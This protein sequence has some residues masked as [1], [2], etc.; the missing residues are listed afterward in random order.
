MVS[1]WCIVA[2][3]WTSCAIFGIL[4]TF[5]LVNTEEQQELM[6]T[7]QLNKQ[8]FPNGVETDDGLNDIL[9]T[10][11][12]GIVFTTETIR[13]KKGGS[14]L[15]WVSNWYSRLVD[16]GLSNPLVIGM[17]EQTCSIVR[18][19][20]MIC[21]SFST[22]DFLHVKPLPV[23]HT[24]NAQHKFHKG[25]A[26]DI[27]F[28]YALEFIKRGKRVVFSDADVYWNVNPLSRANDVDMRG[29]SDDLGAHDASDLWTSDECGASYG[30]PCMSTGLWDMNPT[31]GAEKYL[32][33]VVGLIRTT[34]RWEQ[35]IA[36]ACL[37][38]HRN[39]MRFHIFSKKTHCNVGVLDKMKRTVSSMAAVHLGYIRTR[40]KI[41]EYKRRGI[42]NP[43]VERDDG[44]SGKSAHSEGS[45]AINEATNPPSNQPAAW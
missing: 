18:K 21:H 32:R 36:N 9:A 26:V 20:G 6:S 38:Q 27:K 30:T 22:G 42:W 4:S 17:D 1:R 28:F 7:H 12:Q 35:E 34:L 11:P 40:H 37:V 16:I 45:P 39:N 5:R 14:R 15:Q 3:I 43:R 29:L 33:C 44:R 24:R 25:A 13:N 31:P 8:K 10:R 23:S 2:Y 19:N 41:G